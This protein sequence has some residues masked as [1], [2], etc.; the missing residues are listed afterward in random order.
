MLNFA[1]GIARGM[2]FLHSLEPG[3]NFNLNSKNVVIDD[4]LTPKLNMAQCKFSFTEK[5]KIFNPAW[6]APECNFFA[7]IFIYKR[8]YLILIII[9]IL[10]F[11]ITKE[12]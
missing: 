12:T 3:I 7:L 2:E 11:S 4:D 9:L 5:Y 8:F 1:I 10:I 6:M